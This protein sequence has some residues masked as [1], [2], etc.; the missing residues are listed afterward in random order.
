MRL[1]R[2]GALFL[3]GARAHVA[4][5]NEPTRVVGKA[6]DRTPAL[7]R[8]V[9]AAVAT[10][11]DAER[12]VCVWLAAGFTLADIAAYLEVS[13]AE[14]SGQFANAITKLQGA[15]PDDC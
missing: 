1:P 5:Q 13:T 14:A 7:E 6:Y 4:I 11:T 9:A 2:A 10:L 8:Q 15:M 12:L 3:I